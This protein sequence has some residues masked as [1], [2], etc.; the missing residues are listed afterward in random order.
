M[1]VCHVDEEGN[2]YGKSFRP[3]STDMASLVEV[4]EAV[5]AGDVLVIDAHGAGAMSLARQSEDSAVFGVFVNV[6]MLNAP[7]FGSQRK[8]PEMP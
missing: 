1:D 2:V 5:E 3:S 8:P 4:S 7:P 6:L